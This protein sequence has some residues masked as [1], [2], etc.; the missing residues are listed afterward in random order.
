MR[1]TLEDVSTGNWQQ[2][3]ELA[4]APH[5]R[6]FVAS[7]A[8]SLAESKYEPAAVPKAIV[9]DGLPVG[10]LMYDA[11]GGVQPRYHLYRFMIDER[12]RNRGYGRSALGL[13]IDQIARAHE[14]ARLSVCYE[15]ENQTARKLYL[16]FGFVETG[17]DEDGEMIAERLVEPVSPGSNNP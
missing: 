1:I 17:V 8:Y 5:E 16:L 2:I 3:V 6:D 10:F 13:L 14:T 4:V 15:P 12:H 11:S 9:A 7:N